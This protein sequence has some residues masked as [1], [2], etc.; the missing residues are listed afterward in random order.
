M[1]DSWYSDCITLQYAL[2]KR[3]DVFRTGRVGE[4]MEEAKRLG[5]AYIHDMK[6][7]LFRQVYGCGGAG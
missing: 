4:V 1:I 2:N 5:G 7:K 3:P 6:K